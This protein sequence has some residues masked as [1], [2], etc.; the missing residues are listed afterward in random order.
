MSPSD[1]LR[2]AIKGATKEVL[3]A[4][5]NLMCPLVGHLWGGESP[6]HRTAEDTVWAALLRWLWWPQ[7]PFL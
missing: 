4:T 2:M 6:S 1:V 3:V 7:G 5:L